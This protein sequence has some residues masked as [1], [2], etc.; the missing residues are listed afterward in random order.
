MCTTALGVDDTLRNTLSV[1][2]RDEVDQVEVL[3]KEWAV[4]TSTLSLIWV[5]YW[6]TIAG[7]VDGL[8]ARSA[9]IIFVCPEFSSKG[10]AVGLAVA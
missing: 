3:K 9:A 2:V 8:L 1:E 5:R 10:F 7:G 6:N 4:D